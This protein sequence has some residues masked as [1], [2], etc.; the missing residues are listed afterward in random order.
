MQFENDLKETLLTDDYTNI[1]LT[2]K[3]WV[4]PSTDC[5]LILTK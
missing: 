5:Q 3:H 1:K 4:D 2:V